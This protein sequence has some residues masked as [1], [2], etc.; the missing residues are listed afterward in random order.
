MFPKNT[1]TIHVDY[2]GLIPMGF[3]IEVTK[4]NNQYEE[5]NL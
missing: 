4:E 5:I 2:R 3:A 1:L